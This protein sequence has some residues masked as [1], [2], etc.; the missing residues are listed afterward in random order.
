MVGLTALYGRVFLSILPLHLFASAFKL[1]LSPRKYHHGRLGKK[2]L[3]VNK[4]E[5]HGEA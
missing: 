1:S 2:A 5:E 4:G 3:Y